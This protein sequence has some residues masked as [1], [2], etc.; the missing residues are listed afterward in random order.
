MAACIES[1]CGSSVMR[2]NTSDFG[3][4]IHEG[5]Y[6]LTAAVTRRVV[7]VQTCG[8]WHEESQPRE[9]GGPPLH[10]V[11]RPAN[12]VLSALETLF[13][14]AEAAALQESFDSRLRK[15][16]EDSRHLITG[17]FV[18]VYCLPA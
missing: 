2:C 16:R 6:K 1:I 3:P 18:S 10:F 11:R 12:L 15:L 9:N 17:V 7:Q 5:F 13:L 4:V 8:W 14:G